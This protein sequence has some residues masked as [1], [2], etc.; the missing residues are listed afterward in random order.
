MISP[1][2][3]RPPGSVPPAR[4]RHRRWPW[5]SAAAIAVILAVIAAAALGLGAQPAAAPLS[6]PRSAAAAP[7]GPLA[8]SWLT[9]PGS[10]AGFRLR[11][12]VLGFGNDVVG[13]TSAVTGT[14]AISGGQ[15]T[16]ARLRVRLAAIRVGGKVQ[17]QVAISLRTSR[18][19]FA[20]ITLSRPVVLPAGFA[21]GAPVT[22]RAAG[23]LTLNG[24]TRPVTITVSGRRDGREI[25]LAGSIPVAFGTWHIQGPGGAGFLGSLARSGRAEFRLVLVRAA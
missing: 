17:R 15:V 18:Y 2:S 3:L 1:A 22:A 11:E 20:T 23:E 9:A 19:P 14:A 12:S 8:G 5:I 21:A 10:A 16:S 24:L 6:L 13:R 4:R 25:Q 7:A